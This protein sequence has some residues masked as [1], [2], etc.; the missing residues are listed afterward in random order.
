MDT[1]SVP[2]RHDFDFLTGDWQ[3]RHRRLRVRLAGCTD[4]DDFEGSCR[5]WPLMGGQANVDD[6]VL[7]LPS[8]RYRAVTLRSFDARSGLWSIW[9]LDGRHPDNL[10][11]P[12]RGGFR[13]GIGTFFADDVFEG[14]PIRV[15]FQW[16]DIGADRCQWQQAFSTDAGA[17]WETNWTMQ[18]RRRGD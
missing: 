12:V 16:S 2:P 6:N 5:A 15:R 10:D 18:F 14:R 9:W 17:T 7:D 8:G 4:W 1:P 3:V 11:I 13:D